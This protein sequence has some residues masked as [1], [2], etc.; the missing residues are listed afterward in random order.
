[1]FVELFEVFE[2]FRLGAHRVF[3]GS[4]GVIIYEGDEVA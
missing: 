3:D 4:I 1:M 2:G